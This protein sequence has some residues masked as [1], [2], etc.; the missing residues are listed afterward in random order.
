M[1]SEGQLPPSS[2]S[3]WSPWRCLLCHLHSALSWQWAKPFQSS[4]P[5][6]GIKAVVTMKQWIA[7]TSLDHSALSVMMMETSF[8]G[9][10]RGLPGTVGAL[11]SRV[12]RRYRIQQH[13]LIPHL[14]TAV[15]GFSNVYPHYTKSFKSR[16]L[17]KTSKNMY[18][19][20]NRSSTQNVKT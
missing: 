17:Y 5:C 2:S 8:Q 4:P 15:S 3:S 19:I 9:S 12:E 1:L 16:N 13:H 11:T 14:L 20:M 10:A 6:P 7:Q 18:N